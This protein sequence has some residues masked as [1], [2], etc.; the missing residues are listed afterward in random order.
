VSYGLQY[1]VPLRHFVEAFTNTRFEP[2]GITDDAD[3]RIAT[4][5]LDYIFRRL[6]VDYLRYEER[7]ELGILTTGE[8]TQP[9]LPGVEE[10]VVQTRQGQ[11]V[12]ADPPS[13]DSS[14]PSLFDTNDAPKEPSLLERAGVTEPDRPSAR[15]NPALNPVQ[16]TS[17]DAPYCMQ[18]GVQMQ[19]AGSCHACPSCGSTSGCS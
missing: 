19:R 7:A 17:A 6:A 14:S 1:G 16:A 8:R 12:A 11:D 10:T 5:I 18:C 9:T 2:A 13:I 15:Q 4:S 3:L